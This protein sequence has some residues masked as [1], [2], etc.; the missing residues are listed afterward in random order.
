MKEIPDMTM[1]E[2]REFASNTYRWHS[3]PHH[4]SF[5]D[6]VNMLEMQQERIEKLDDISYELEQ[7]LLQE[8]KINK[9]KI[10]ENNKLILHNLK[11]ERAL[12]YKKNKQIQALE[13]EIEILR[14]YGN[15]DCTSM[16]DERLEELDESITKKT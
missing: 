13:K 6:M 12:R 14:L 8:R 7:N 3:Q 2:L 15:K 1:E 16:A 11:R 9:E 4:R 5:L 10:D